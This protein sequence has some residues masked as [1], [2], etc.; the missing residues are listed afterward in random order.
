MVF[1]MMD[2][3]ARHIAQLLYRS[4]AETLPEAQQQELDAWLSQSPRHRVLHEQLQQE[5]WPAP[6][7]QRYYA[8]TTPQFENELYTMVR[9]G[10]GVSAPLERKTGRVQRLPAFRRWW[11]AASLLLVLGV[12]AYLRTTYKKIN[13]PV[14]AMADA[15][16][17]KPGT[18]GAVLTLA[19][20]SEIL[21]DTIRN[22]T[23][24][25]QGGATAKVVNGG[26]VYEAVGG[27]AVYNTMS[28][29]RGR[30]YHVTLPDGSEVW[31]NS[32]SSIR[33]PTVFS[34]KERKVTI[35]GEAYFEVAQNAQL[36]FR[37]NANNKATVEVLG[38]HFNVNA[39]EN[40]Q[41]VNT[42][43]LE[44]SVKVNERLITPGQQAQVGQAAGVVTIVHH[45]D[46]EKIMA[47]KNGAFNFEGLGVEEAMRQLERWYD[48]EVVYEK[49]I[50]NIAFFG[51]ISRNLNL[52]DLLEVLDRAD[53]HFRITGRKLVVTK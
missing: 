21:L 48:I 46:T 49:D 3:Q 20:G 37:V 7:M 36:P 34:G 39:Y 14:V 2:Q 35:T 11:V 1:Q 44:G 18:D 26:L 25:L 6:D 13:V 43:L 51:A 16:K 17:I 12:G 23:I 4:L 19:N 38:T 8:A 53:L 32:A 22:A 50:P 27:E 33:F 30:Q 29:P 28:T 52:F 10:T 40:E 45:A 9:Q 24:A 41:T 47:W 15:A 31:L 5:T 42:T